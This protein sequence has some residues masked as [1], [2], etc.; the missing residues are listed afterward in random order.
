LRSHHKIP[1]QATKDAGENY[2][3]EYL[4]EQLFVIR[5]ICHVEYGMRIA[6][7]WAATEERVKQW[8]MILKMGNAIGHCTKSGIC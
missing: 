8:D 3:R 1:T 5:E 6:V 4:H 7:D 2:A